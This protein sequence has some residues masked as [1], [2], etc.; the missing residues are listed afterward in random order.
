MKTETLNYQAP[1]AKVVLLVPE[2][3]LLTASGLESG[4]EGLDLDFADDLEW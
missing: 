1:Q 3:C 4:T 2:C